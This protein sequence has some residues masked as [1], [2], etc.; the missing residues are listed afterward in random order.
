MIEDMDFSLIFFA[1]SIIFTGKSFSEKILLTKPAL[2][3]S[4][5]SIYLPVKCI[6]IALDLPTV[7]GSLCVPPIPAITP[8]LISGCPNLAESEANIISHIIANSHPPPKA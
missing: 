4:C 3:A 5:A 1:I 6:S 7:F 8:R 2:S